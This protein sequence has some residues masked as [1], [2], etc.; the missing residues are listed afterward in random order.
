MTWWRK[1]EF[2]N[3]SVDSFEDNK[4][5]HM[6][7]LDSMWKVMKQ[8][9]SSM[10]FPNFINS[11]TFIV[12]FLHLFHSREYDIYPIMLMYLIIFDMTSSLN[13]NINSHIL[14]HGNKFYMRKLILKVMANILSVLSSL[15][16]KCCTKV[17]QM[18]K[19]LN[20][21]NWFYFVRFK[22]VS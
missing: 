18:F 21:Q 15:A 16:N 6:N 13:K 10:Y 11:R 8:S 14:K 2:D 17:N 4:K 7:V 19:H 22:W 9:N 12:N 5:K 20:K 1:R 3:D